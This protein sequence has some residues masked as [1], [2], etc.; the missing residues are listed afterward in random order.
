[1]S[2]LTESASETSLDGPESR[3]LSVRMVRKRRFLGGRTGRLSITDSTRRR[4]VS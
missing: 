1:M 4:R 3:E 2:G